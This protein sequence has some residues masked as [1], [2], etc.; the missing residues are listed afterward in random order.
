[1][2]ATKTTIA[3]LVVY[4]IKENKIAHYK[5]DG[6][7]EFRTFINQFEGLISV[8]THTSMKEEGVFMDLVEWE[9][10]DH[11]LKAAEA[12]KQIEKDPK[13]AEMLGVFEEIKLFDHYNFLK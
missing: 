6:I 12:F 7:N 8:K 10:M 11:A 3:E 2:I 1:M 5:G 4:K 13:Y 9:S